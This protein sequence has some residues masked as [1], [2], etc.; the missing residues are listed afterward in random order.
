[1]CLSGNKY[2][3]SIL[4]KPDGRDYITL[5]F[6][7]LSTTYSARFN[8][9]DGTKAFEGSDVTASIKK[10]GT[11]GFLCTIQ[12]DV[13]LSG[14]SSLTLYLHDSDTSTTSYTGDGVSGIY[15]QGYQIE[16]NESPTSYIPT[17]GTT[18]PRLEDEPLVNGQSFTDFF[19][20]NEG[21]WL[22]VV[23]S[24]NFDKATS[25]DQQLFIFTRDL[26][27]A[28][29]RHSIGRY[30]GGSNGFNYYIQD[31]ADQAYLVSSY[32][33]Q[34]TL[35][36]AASYKLND[37]ATYLDGGDKQTDSSATMPTGFD[38]LTI[39]YKSS[40]PSN[41][42]NGHIKRVVYFPVALNDEQLSLLTTTYNY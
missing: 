20:E 14:N 11:N 3:A 21:T 12:T 7:S 40:S 1:V 34:V 4:V 15:M 13:A 26:T 16:P 10:M 5:W 18:V 19:N 38:E 31:G 35:K 6:A 37:V 36:F 24:N 9:S 30:N 23:S 22:V 8:L 17:F 42:I 28:T 39:G 25:S 27:D 33:D 41:N 2:S 32:T 29:K